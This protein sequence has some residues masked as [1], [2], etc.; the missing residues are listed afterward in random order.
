[1]N[2]YLIH[3]INSFTKN[4]KT[5]ETTKKTKETTKKTKETTKTQRKQPKH[6]GNNQN[7]KEKN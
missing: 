5:K 6:K 1:M 7:T 4:K 3:C 2:I